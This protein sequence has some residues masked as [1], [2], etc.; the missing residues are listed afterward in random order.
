MSKKHNLPLRLKRFFA[1]QQG[2]SLPR[3]LLQRAQSGQQI[4][5]YLADVPDGRT[6][7]EMLCQLAAECQFPLDCQ[8]LPIPL[9]VC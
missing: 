6:I 2:T 3:G 9:H 8:L 5:L 4:R 7:N 1:A